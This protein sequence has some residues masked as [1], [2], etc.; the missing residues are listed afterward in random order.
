MWRPPDGSDLTFEHPCETA[1]V[2]PRGAQAGANFWPGLRTL[3]V[4][5]LPGMRADSPWPWHTCLLCSKFINIR[6]QVIRVQA[7]SYDG[8]NSVRVRKCGVLGCIEDLPSHGNT[9]FGAPFPEF[10]LRIARRVRQSGKHYSS[11]TSTSKTDFR[12]DRWFRVRYL[13]ARSFFY[14]VACAR[15]L[16]SARHATAISCISCMSFRTKRHK[17]FSDVLP[18]PARGQGL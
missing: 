17:T 18:S 12:S 8:V 7:A 1:I 16:A 13:V 2:D 10:G 5:E 14:L 4:R 11:T 6:G 3:I 9:R 15:I